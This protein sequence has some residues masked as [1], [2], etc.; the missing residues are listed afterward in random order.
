MRI[1]DAPNEQTWDGETVTDLFHQ[2]TSGS[3]SRTSDVL[4]SVVVNDRSNDEVDHGDSRLTDQ[5]TFGVILDVPHLTDN[6]EETWCSGVSKDDDVKSIDSVDES[7][8]GGSLD[9]D[10]EGSS[11]GSGTGSIGDTT[12]DGQGD[13]GGDDRDDTDPSDPGYFVEGLNTRHQKGNDGPDNDKNDCTCSVHR[14]G[15]Q[16]D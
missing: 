2:D 9:D 11:L 8:I 15:V 7:R 12:G 13:D 1:D 4:T 3:K 6:V 16:C 5:D 14:D 10:F